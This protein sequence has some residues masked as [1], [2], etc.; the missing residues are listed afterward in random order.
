MNTR[1]GTT[2]SLILPLLPRGR[3]DPALAEVLREYRGGNS[4]PRTSAPP[5]HCTPTQNHH[6]PID[7]YSPLH[8]LPVSSGTAHIVGRI[9]YGGQAFIAKSNCVLW[10][11]FSGAFTVHHV[12][13]LDMFAQFRLLCCLPMDL[14]V[15]LPSPLKT[16]DYLHLRKLSHFFLLSSVF[17][18][19]NSSNFNVVI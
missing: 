6:R 9:F 11:H 2:T 19:I 5:S 7:V 3:P 8:F 16:K 17:L 4:G 18:W 14:N 13:F 15:F 10:W 12:V 1:L